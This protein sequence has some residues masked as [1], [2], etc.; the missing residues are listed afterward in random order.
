M[1]KLR[2]EKPASA[3]L[4]PAHGRKKLVPAWMLWLRK[5]RTWMLL[6]LRRG[7]SGN[8]KNLKM[9]VNMVPAWMPRN[10]TCK[11]KLLRRQCAGDRARER[12]RAE[13][14]KVLPR[15]RL[16][17]GKALRGMKGTLPKRLDMCKSG[18]MCRT[19]RSRKRHPHPGI[20]EAVKSF[21]LPH[22]N[23][24]FGI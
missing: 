7:C 3:N 1:A 4:S 9:D 22:P 23:P 21:L 16:S 8:P 13:Q 20:M 19:C 11:N 14:L 15:K 18:Q 17:S 24:L 12:S 2:F 5:I 10:A 6:W